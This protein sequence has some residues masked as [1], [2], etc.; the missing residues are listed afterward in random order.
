M[1][2]I[3]IQSLEFVRAPGDYLVTNRVR[4]VDGGGSGG[5][6]SPGGGGPSV[7]KSGVIDVVP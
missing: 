6:V 5:S 3:A 4:L 1:N 7:V 2:T